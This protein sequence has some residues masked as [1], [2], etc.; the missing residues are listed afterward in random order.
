[1]TK[2]L[3]FNTVVGTF[4]IVKDI[5]GSYHPYYDEHDLGR[6]DTLVD[7]IE[8]VANDSSF[9]VMHPEMGDPL[10]PSDLGVPDDISG[11]TPV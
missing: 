2:L 10:D 3:Y 5:H 9:T 7:A 1:M 4:Y 11:W 8:G 6:Y